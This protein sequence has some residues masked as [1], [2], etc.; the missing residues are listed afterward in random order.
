MKMKMKVGGSE[1]WSG[2]C[3]G[4]SEEVLKG[5]VVGGEG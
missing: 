1:G 5:R 3:R 2:M 4:R